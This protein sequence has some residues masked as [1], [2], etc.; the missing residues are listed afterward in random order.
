MTGA[1]A[2]VKMIAPCVISNSISISMILVEIWGQRFICS[3]S[4]YRT[5]KKQKEEQGKRIPTLQTAAHV[6]KDDAA[7]YS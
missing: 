7:S 6:L 4:A 2:I 5:V 1:R 3:T